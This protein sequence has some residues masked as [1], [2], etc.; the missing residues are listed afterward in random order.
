[1]VGLG[2]KKGPGLTSRMPYIR[3]GATGSHRD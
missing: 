1:M 3:A 2:A